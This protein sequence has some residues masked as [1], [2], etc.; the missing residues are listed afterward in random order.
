[1]TNPEQKIVQYLSEAHASEVTLITVLRSQISM[2]PAGTYRDGLEKHLEETRNHAD[3]VQDRLSALGGETSPLQA[4][5][6]FT[7]TMIGQ[8]FALGKAPLDLLRGSG[9]PERA[10][11]NAKDACAAE[12][13][14]IATYT[15][16][17]RAASR[18]GDTQTAKLAASIRADEERM[19]KRLMREIPGLADEVVAS[20]L[21]EVPDR[22]ASTRASAPSRAA[23]KQTPRKAR[24]RS[25]SAAAQPRTRPRRGHE[26]RTNRPEIAEQDLAVER[27][28]SLSAENI[29]EQL[30]PL[31]Q[32]ELTRI[33]TYE[34]GHENRAAVLSGV[35]EL[36]GE[37]PWP[38]YDELSSQ[39]IETALLEGDEQ[40][41]KA[42]VAY[43]RVHKRRP[44]VLQRA[45]VPTPRVINR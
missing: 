40:R 16:L 11:K 34:R 31:S 12:A 28:G 14:E 2:A 8:A 26:G 38:G 39:E 19:L 30:P 41:A 4:L 27:Y 23:T 15:A 3:R 45:L 21:A 37:E 10:L 24:T 33:D 42:V 7:E 35:A 43:E 18:V 36:R 1:M 29:V 25:K 6:G 20:D 5:V 17:E 13:L 22:D 44:D 32:Q 9:D